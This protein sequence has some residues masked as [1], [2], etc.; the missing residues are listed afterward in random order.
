MCMHFEQVLLNSY[1]YIYISKY[2]HTN[3][4]TYMYVHAYTQHI[5][6]GGQCTWTLER[7]NQICIQTCIY[8]YIYTYMY[9][10][11]YIQYKRRCGKCAWTWERFHRIR[12]DPQPQWHVALAPCMWVMSY[13]SVRM[14]VQTLVH[15]NTRQHIAK[16]N[17]MLQ[18]TATRYNTLGL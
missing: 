15:P 12:N 13:M 18:H 6:R 5:Y 7:I 1:T 8:E 14:W 9:L 11:A 16:H 3:M 2:W 17:N 10:H 4:H